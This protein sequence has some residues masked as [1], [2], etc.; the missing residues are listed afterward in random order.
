MTKGSLKAA[1][2]DALGLERL[3][4]FSDAVMAIAITLLAVDIHVPDFPSG[5]SA[6]L[7][8]EQFSQLSPQITSFVIS[9]TVIGVYW[10]AHNRYFAWIQHHD[11]RLIALN[12][13]FLFF[14]AAIPFVAS[15][16]GHYPGLAI[17]V[18]PYAIDVAALG[19]AMA[20]I[21]WYASGD[22]HLVD[23]ELD[24]T[25]ILLFRIRPLATAVVFFLSVPIAIWR[26]L[27]G[28]WFW[29][30]APVVVAVMPRLLGRSRAQQA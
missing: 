29:M 2:E 7:V 10:A 27:A 5:V 18:V 9:F 3:V 19:L 14:V 1:A 17:G 28:T 20:A 8:G 16:L 30:L 25:T 6:P 13:A 24:S 4:F 15:L 23:P 11:G 26:P 21:W 12:L 22:A